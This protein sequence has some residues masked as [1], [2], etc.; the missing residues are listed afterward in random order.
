M[1]QIA[2]AAAGGRDHPDRQASDHSPAQ[3]L[4]ER[5]GGQRVGHPDCEDPARS[6]G[7]GIDLLAEPDEVTASLIAGSGDGIIGQRSFAM[8]AAGA[9]E[10]PSRGHM[11]GH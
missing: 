1:A 8:L 4:D 11:M 10:T 3:V 7:L 5:R 6:P 2:P 9:A